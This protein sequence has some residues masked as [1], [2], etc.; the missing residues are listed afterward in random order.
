MERDVFEMRR[1]GKLAIIGSGPS[2]LYLLK[3]LSDQIATLGGSLD[4]VVIFEK[5]ALAGYGM[6]YHPETTDRYNRANISSEELPELPVA[7]V[8]W[9][10][11]KSKDK[12]EAWGIEKE[13]IRAADVYCRLALGEYFHEQFQRIIA[14]LTAGEIKVDIRVSCAIHDLEHSPEE[15]LVRVSTDSSDTELFDTVVIAT[16]HRWLDEDRPEEGFYSSPWPI[17]KL[18]PGEGEFFNF[19]VGTLGASL[20]A[21]DVISSLSHRHGNFVTRPEGL[22]FEALEGAEE[23]EL[24]MHSSEGWLPHLQWDQVEPF[25]EIYR[26]TTHEDLFALRDRHGLLKLEIFFH[27]VCRPAL[28]DAFEK[29]K[30]PVLAEMLRGEEVGIAEFVQAMSERHAYVDSFEGMR[31][32][33]QNARE[34]VENHRP[35]HWKET[36]DDLMYC[37][38]YHAELLAAEDHIIL[39]KTVM[40]FL[41]NVIA[42]MPLESAEMLLAL[43]DAGKIRLVAGKVTIKGVGSE[44]GTT[45]ISID[46]VA[47]SEETEY[48]MFVDCSGQKAMELDDFPFAS[49]VKCGA[50]C[51]AKA[52]FREAESAEEVDSGK[53][54]KEGEKIML[55]TGGINIDAAF[56]IIGSDGVSNPRIY[57]ISFPH[58][59]GVRP[60][61]YGLQACATTAEIVVR[62]WIDSESSRLDAAET[63]EDISASYIT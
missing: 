24:V 58:T 13:A 36:L 26:H 47:R 60:Y 56:R 27:R 14:D 63:L 7:F 31:L 28:I 55:K 16:G 21:F 37:L 43:H 25:R 18:L 41:M 34:S 5:S 15:N 6:P 48:K 2:G 29:D 20:S 30:M 57:D 50:V 35:I 1:L 46:D 40:P 19:P 22:I 4:G 39:R 59:S 32:E 52:E 10:R 12:L 17:N 49:L 51:E 33:L 62:S 3:H 42:A 44:P 54:I 9:L 23:F 61:S 8:D 53:L 45:R 11:A 38:N